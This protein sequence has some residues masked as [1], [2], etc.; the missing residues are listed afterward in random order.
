MYELNFILHVLLFCK[1]FFLH[2]YTLS[3]MS[4]KLYQQKNLHWPCCVSILYSSVNVDIKFRYKVEK[5]K[6]TFTPQQK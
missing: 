6:Q 5:V 2:T 1:M 4:Q 3:C